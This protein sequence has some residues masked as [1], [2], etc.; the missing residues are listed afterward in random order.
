M[1]K[2]TARVIGIIFTGIILSGCY[3]VT[4][5]TSTP[6]TTQISMPSPVDPIGHIRV[7]SLEVGFEFTGFE[8]ALNLTANIIYTG[9]DT[10]I[11]YSISG[12]TCGDGG[13]YTVLDSVTD[14]IVDGE[15][16]TGRLNYIY[17][18]CSLGAGD[19]ID[20][21]LTIKDLNSGY[22][23]VEIVEVTVG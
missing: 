9:P 22:Q 13:S 11:E 12:L 1:K 23:F 21:K 5:P 15:F 6:Q 19:V 20:L 7:K 14:T 16:Y 3:E 10:N 2:S 4:G 18:G 17:V 8:T